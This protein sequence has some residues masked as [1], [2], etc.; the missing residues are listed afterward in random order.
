MVLITF[1]KKISE[2]LNPLFERINAGYFGIISTISG[3]LTIL[4][5][6]ILYFPIEPFN[7]TT[8]WISN[9][10][11][12]I[13]NSGESP[14]YSYVVFSIGLTITAIFTTL[15]ITGLIRDLLSTS[16]GFKS[17]ISMGFIVSLFSLIGSLGVGCFNMKS[18]PVIHTYFAISF[19]FGSSLMMIL[20]SLA[21][22]MN[23]NYHWLVGVMGVFLATPAV[24]FELSFIPHLLEGKDIA[25][26]V[27]STGPELALSRL[28]EWIFVFALFIWLFGIGLYMLKKT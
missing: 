23:E 20:F 19:F 4:I 24:L 16:Q 26:L 25:S 10:G 11:G 28:L 12:I 15:F 22:I 8:H 2:K 13:T 3:A 17:F 7:F 21:I 5:A 18:F 27:V 6:S 9:L 1:L 14:N